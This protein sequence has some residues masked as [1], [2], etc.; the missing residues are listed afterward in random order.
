MSG[1]K[2]N[3]TTTVLP[4]YNAPN[5]NIPTGVLKAANSPV[6]ASIP[7][8]VSI[9]KLPALNPPFVQALDKTVRSVEKYI[10]EDQREM[11]ENTLRPKLEFQDKKLSTSD[12]LSLLSLLVTIFFGILSTFPNEQLD[13]ISEK[14]DTLIAQQEQIIELQQENQELRNTL[15]DLADAINGLSERLEDLGVCLEDSQNTADSQGQA[16]DFQG[17]YKTGDTQQ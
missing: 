16:S 8:T 13:R 2:F 4:V 12:L 3:I 15:E 17:E 10:P 6:I 9:T 11:Y 1:K 14:E 5:I 7:Y